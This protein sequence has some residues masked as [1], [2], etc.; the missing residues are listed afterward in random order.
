MEHGYYNGWVGKNHTPIGQK[1]KRFGYKSGV[2]DTSFDFWY[3]GHGHLSFYPKK[4]T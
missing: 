2:M 3:A 1:G 4:K